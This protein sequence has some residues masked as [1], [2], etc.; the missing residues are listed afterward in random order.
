VQILTASDNASFESQVVADNNLRSRF[1]KVAFR[2]EQDA[3]PFV[4]DKL[5]ADLRELAT[6][7][8]KNR[9]VKV[10]LQSDDLNDPQLLAALKKF[11][12]SVDSRAEALNMMMIEMPAGAAQ[13]IASLQAAKHLSLD[14]K[15]A[16][17]GHVETTTGATLVRGM[18]NSTGVLGAVTAIPNLLGLGTQLDGTGVGIAIVDSGI[19]GTHHHFIDDNGM[20]RI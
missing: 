16:S 11:D 17:L 1:E 2:S 18:L 10:I 19:M 8:D 12:V 14:H 15:V 5:S 3:D 7:A 9:T 6:G 4:G 20:C 13:E